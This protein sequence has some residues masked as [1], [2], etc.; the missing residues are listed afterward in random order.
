VA[1]QESWMRGAGIIAGLSSSTKGIGT[2]CDRTRYEWSGN[3]QRFP[4]DEVAPIANEFIGKIRSNWGI[5]ETHRWFSDNNNNE[6]LDKQLQFKKLKNWEAL[7]PNGLGELIHLLHA[8]GGKPNCLNWRNCP[9][10]GGS[11]GCG[12]LTR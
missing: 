9:G 2:D 10:W 8:H 12:E 6:V 4:G 11:V 1:I 3:L 7:S 5:S